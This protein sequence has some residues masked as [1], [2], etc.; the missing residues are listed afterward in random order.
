[1]DAGRAP[2]GHG[3]EAGHVGHEN[4]WGRIERA[5]SFSAEGEAVVAPGAHIKLLI[6]SYRYHAL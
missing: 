3:V 4:Q 5:Q 1:M 2:I 6:E